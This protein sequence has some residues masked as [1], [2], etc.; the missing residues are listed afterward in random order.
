MKK[1]YFRLKPVM[2]GFSSKRFLLVV[3]IVSVTVG[4]QA[5]L[6]IAGKQ[7]SKC[8]DDSCSVRC[9]GYGVRGDGYGVRHDG[10]GVRGDGYDV[11]DDG[12]RVRDDGY[13]G[14]GVGRDAYC[15]G[16]GVRGDSY[17]CS[18]MEHKDDHGKDEGRD[19]GKPAAGKRIFSRFRH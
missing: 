3:A 5:S 7:D 4:F 8:R 6:A 19:R 15:H 2:S 18:E 12:Y 1:F 9:G 11:R 10:Y 17:S 13:C 16:G 14:A